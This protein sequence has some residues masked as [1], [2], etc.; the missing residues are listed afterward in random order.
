[1]ANITFD[2]ANAQ[3]V[4]L[5]SGS[6]PVEYGSA[7]LKDVMAS[8]LIMQAGKYEPMSASSKKIDV[9]TGGP[10]AYWVAEGERIKTGKPTWKTVTLQ[11]HKLGVILPVSREYLTYK[12]SDFFEIMRPLLAEALYKKFDH[13]AIT[14]VG[15]PF[16]YSIADSLSKS[17]NS[18]A[19]D[20]TAANYA[21]AVGYLND[22]GFEP[23][24]FIS[25]VANASILRGLIRDQ[26]GMLTS[27]YDAGTKTLDGVPVLDLA[28]DVPDFEKGT[29]VAGDFNQIRYGIPYNMNYMLSQDATLTT[30]TQNSNG[31]VAGDG[32]DTVLNLF[33][34]EM[35][36][37][38][39]TMD[40]AF[41]ILDDNAF[42][43]LVS[44]PLPGSIA[45]TY[46][47]GPTVK[48]VTVPAAVG[49]VLVAPDSAQIKLIAA[50]DK[51]DEVSLTTSNATPSVLKFVAS[52]NYPIN[53]IIDINFPAKTATITTTGVTTS[54]VGDLDGTTIEGFK[55][56]G[57]EKVTVVPNT[58]SVELQVTV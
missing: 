23:N 48:E 28:N 51:T 36:A 52:A 34:R 38:R 11:A 43:Q 54:I 5:L 53:S 2:P 32:T 31:G 17:K 39:V 3:M 37:L 26:N 7:I 55:V 19:G 35:V 25:K 45:K 46:V 9:L 47:V 14:G 6:V 58:A 15:S 4:N 24:A 33:E 27:I 49:D 18:V 41:M 42:S 50:V 29:I 20:F 16:S 57:S 10:A 56:A 12:Q 44:T 22:N 40:V 13:A 30:I 8:S 1:M 21:K